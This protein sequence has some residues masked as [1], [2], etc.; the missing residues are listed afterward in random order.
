[1]DDQLGM[2]PLS[3]LGKNPP[4][5]EPAPSV[6]ISMACTMF[7]TVQL[8]QSHLVMNIMGEY[9]QKQHFVSKFS[10]GFGSH[11]LRLKGA[12]GH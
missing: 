9:Q 6:S 11:I 7:I 12:L 4:P 5:L 1:M 10:R 2:V 8:V 3:P